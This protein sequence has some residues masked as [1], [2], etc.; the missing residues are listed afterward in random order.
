M[1]LQASLCWIEPQK[2]GAV[3]R[4]VRP[5]QKAKIEVTLKNCS[6]EAI[7][8]GDRRHPLSLAC[9]VRHPPSAHYAS[10][11]HSYPAFTRDKPR[12]SFCREPRIIALQDQLY[13]Y[14]ANRL[15]A[16]EPVNELKPVRFPPGGSLTFHITLDF[17]VANEFEVALL[18]GQRSDD[19]RNSWTYPS[20]FLRL[21]VTDDRPAVRDGVSLRLER[22][23][24]AQPTGAIPLKAIFSN[25]SGKTVRFQLSQR[26]PLQLFAYDSYGTL[27]TEWFGG[28]H[29]PTM[30]VA[31]APGKEHAVSLEAPPRSALARTVFFHGYVLRGSDDGSETLNSSFQLVSPAISLTAN[32]TISED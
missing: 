22:G 11:H 24:T 31:L 21:D 25:R 13:E 19:G 5:G 17:P 23:E 3:L 1:P 28:L 18:V 30:A 14:A 29:G 10:Q 26:E 6:A 12:W 32:S 27:L 15:F 16:G 9:D 8:A 7:D 20:N 2:G 4:S